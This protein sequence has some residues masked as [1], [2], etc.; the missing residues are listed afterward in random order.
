MRK[1]K[2][3]SICFLVSSIIFYGV[4]CVGFL[5]HVE[6]DLSIMCLCLGS[7]FLCLGAV[8]RNKR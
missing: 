5:N 1:E 4:A 8:Y 7:C 2:V 3:A 6:K